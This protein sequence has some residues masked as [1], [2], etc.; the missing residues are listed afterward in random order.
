MLDLEKDLGWVEEDFKGDLRPFLRD[1]MDLG[2]KIVFLVAFV[3]L[4]SCFSC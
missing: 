3:D 4:V 1:E 2:E